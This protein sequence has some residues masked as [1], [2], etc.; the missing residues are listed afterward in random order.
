MRIIMISADRKEERIMIKR[1]LPTNDLAFRKAF[2]TSGNEDVLQG[3]I[4][5]F[6]EI[7]PE[8]EDITI[9]NTYD[10]KAYI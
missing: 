10:I 2:A 7:R 4:R 6:F 8:I 9:A 3:I 1:V 5:D